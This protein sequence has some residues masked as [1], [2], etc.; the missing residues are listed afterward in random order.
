MS[1]ICWMLTGMMDGNMRSISSYNKLSQFASHG[2]QKI[3]GE[4]EKAGPNKEHFQI[5]AWS[6]FAIGLISQIKS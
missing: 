1:Y 4:Q 5:S 6:M 3:Q 2:S